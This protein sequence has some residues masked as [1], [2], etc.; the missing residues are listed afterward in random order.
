MV[1]YGKSSATTRVK[2]NMFFRNNHILI[3]ESRYLSSLHVGDFCMT[4]EELV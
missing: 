1:A 3:F 4:S 2:N